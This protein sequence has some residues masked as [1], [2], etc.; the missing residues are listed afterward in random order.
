M[1][2]SDVPKLFING[3]PGTIITGI[4]RDFCRAW[5][6]QEEVTV[7]GLHFLQE[8]SPN[9]IGR[10]IAEWLMRLPFVT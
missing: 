6:R 5:P 8:D 9:E 1:A 3:E 4:L 7:R 2:K 10:A